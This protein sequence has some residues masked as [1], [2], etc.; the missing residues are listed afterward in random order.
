MSSRR[1]ESSNH[2]FFLLKQLFSSIK[3][4]PQIDND[5]LV[6]LLKDLVKIDSVNPSLVPGAAGEAEIAEYS[7][8][9][10]DCPRFRDRAG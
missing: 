2:T 4:S 1:R 6:K 7:E 10:D 9:L 3:L 8:G 5:K